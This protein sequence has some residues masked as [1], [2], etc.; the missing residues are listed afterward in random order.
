MS[1]STA[2]T[3]YIQRAMCQVM[4][5]I[6]CRQQVPEEV[7]QDGRAVRIIIFSARDRGEV[8]LR[9]VP[10]LDER[11]PH[12][13]KKKKTP[14]TPGTCFVGSKNTTADGHGICFRGG[15]EPRSTRSASSQQLGGSHQCREAFARAFSAMGPVS[16]LVLC[17][18]PPTKPPLQL[19][20]SSAKMQS[21]YGRRCCGNI[22]PHVQRWNLR[23]SDVLIAQFLQAVPL[24]WLSC[25]W[26]FRNVVLIRLQR[27]TCLFHLPPMIW[28]FF[29]ERNQPV[30]TVLHR[31]SIL[32]CCRIPA[33]SCTCFHVLLCANTTHSG[34]TLAF[35]PQ[36]RVL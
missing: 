23:T 3:V 7:A 36:E 31:S 28:A 21:F 26:A 34:L 33:R 5:G 29:C 15:R 10:L 8:C 24:V 1:R 30:K 2:R 12:F 20:P 13:T 25:V 4:H 16:H 19:T 6:R 11:C 35:V 17:D 32:R 22:R 18:C 14:P 27:E 9:L